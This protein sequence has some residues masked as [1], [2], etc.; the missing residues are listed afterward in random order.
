MQKSLLA[1][2]VFPPFDSSYLDSTKVS[3]FY[4]VI[5]MVVYWHPFVAKARVRVEQRQPLD[6]SSCSTTDLLPPF[7]TFVDSL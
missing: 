1:L 6:H 5:S 7:F 2:R 4:L 3:G